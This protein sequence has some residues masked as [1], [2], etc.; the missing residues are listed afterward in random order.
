M[1]DQARAATASETEE[2]KRRAFDAGHLKCRHCIG[3]T[4]REDTLEERIQG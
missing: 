1:K 2:V 3:A 4:G